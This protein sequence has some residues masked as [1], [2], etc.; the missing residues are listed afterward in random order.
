MPLRIHI[1]FLD[2]LS[3]NTAAHSFLQGIGRIFDITGSYRLESRR[4]FLTQD[5]QAIDAEA[6]RNDWRVVGEDMY[7]ALHRFEK[8]YAHKR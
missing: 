7:A 3:A 5:S 6:L 1:S 8:E 2:R 4:T